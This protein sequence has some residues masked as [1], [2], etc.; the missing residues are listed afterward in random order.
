M[1]RKIIVIITIIVFS[2]IFLIIGNADEEVVEPTVG[3]GRTAATG[4]E[5]IEELEDI[6]ILSRTVGDV[7][8]NNDISGIESYYHPS[9]N[10]FEGFELCSISI[11]SGAIRYFFMPV[12][13][14]VS[15]QSAFAVGIVITLTRPH[16]V[17]ANDPLGPIINQRIG[18][19]RTPIIENGLLFEERASLGY[20]DMYTQVGN[21][22]MHIRIPRH[23]PISSYESM[24]DLAL[25]EFIPANIMWVDELLAQRGIERAPKTS[26][27]LNILFFAGVMLGAVLA[28]FRV[29]KMRGNKEEKY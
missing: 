18:Q 7:D 2:A 6:I 1:K 21:T 22:R 15:Q 29:I 12:G 27:D 20:N 28:C 23:L 9:E 17:D 11:Y 19:G 10:A 8:P 25:T 3:G 26:D 14:S 5:S 24:L 4:I 16:M 13:V